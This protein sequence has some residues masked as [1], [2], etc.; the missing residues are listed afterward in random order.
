MYYNWDF[1]RKFKLK[2]FL[3]QYKDINYKDSDGNT[4]L[5]EACNDGN[6]KIIKILIKNGADANILDGYYY[7]APLYWFIICGGNIKIV[8]ILL[9]YTSNLLI[10]DTYIKILKY[11]Y[12]HEYVNENTIRLL[13]HYLKF[14]INP[15]LFK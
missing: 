12:K 6:V 8:K 2:K 1:C 9:I 7:N 4:L 3:E 14:M 5:N 15:R 11:K 10:Y 13:Q